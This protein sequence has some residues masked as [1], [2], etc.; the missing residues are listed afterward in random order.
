MDEN[1]KG[2]QQIVQAAVIQ[3]QYPRPIQIQMVSEI[4]HPLHERR[5][6]VRQL[7]WIRLQRLIKQLPAVPAS[8][9][10][11]YSVFFGAGLSALIS[12]PPLFLAKDLPTWVL[13]SE[14]AFCIGSFVLGGGLLVVERR[15]KKEHR[16][17]AED[18]LADMTDIMGQMQNPDSNLEV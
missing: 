18:I 14:I 7:D 6:A 12:L 2:S 15:F 3:G 4:C 16:G 9:A 8:L 17:M 11:W 10:I 13:P 5:F 1:Q